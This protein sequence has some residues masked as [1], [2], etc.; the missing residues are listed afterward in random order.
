MK[1][2]NLLVWILG[3]AVAVL[4]FLFLTK[5]STATPTQPTAGNYNSGWIGTTITPNGQAV[6]NDQ[7]SGIINSSSSLVDSVTGLLSVIIK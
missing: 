3:G 4:G 2:N 1:T 7:W 5:K 6:G